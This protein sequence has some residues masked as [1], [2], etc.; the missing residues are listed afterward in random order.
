MFKKIWSLSDQVILLK[1]LGELLEK[2][3]SLLQALE[4]LR[5]QL[6]LEKKVQLQRMIDGLKMEKSTRFFSSIKVSSGDVK[7]FI[8]CRA[9]W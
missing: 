9:T 7:L 8:L 1:R 2:G 3:Y 4:F 5:F 6:P